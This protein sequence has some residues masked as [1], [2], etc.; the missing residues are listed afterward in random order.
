MADPARVY[1]NFIFL[2]RRPALT[3]FCYERVFHSPVGAQ[4]SSACFDWRRILEAGL[5][6]ALAARFRWD[7][8]TGQMRNCFHLETQGEKEG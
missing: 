4:L 5:T 6:V 7:R 8:T 1:E 3:M 2:Q